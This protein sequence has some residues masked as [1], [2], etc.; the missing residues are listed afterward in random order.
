MRFYDIRIAD[1]NGGLLRRYTSLLPDGTP[2]PNALMVEID[3]SATSYA[4]PAGGSFVRIWG[5][6]LQELGAANNLTG[7]NIAVYGGMSKGLPLANP[8]QQGLLVQGMV[9]QAFGNW[10]GLDMTL[11]LIITAGQPLQNKNTDQVKNLTF[12]WTKGTPLSDII[13]SVL[14]QNYPGTTA[15]INISNK[16]V[17]NYDSPGYYGSLIEF[18]QFLKRISVSVIGTA[19]YQGVDV[20][21]KGN[22][23]AVFDGTTAKTPINISFIDLIG[24]PTW[25]ENQRILVTTVMR[26]DISVGDYIKLPNTQL[27][28]TAGSLSQYRQAPIFQGVYQVGGEYGI[29][30]IG[31]SRQPDGRSWIS[32]FDCY[33]PLPAA[34]GATTASP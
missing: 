15:D 28:T 12:T 18:A 16:L 7:K 1:A 14:G 23:F 21:L 31:S 5:I 2:D 20:V 29:H 22:T 11:D 4:T 10:I 9:Q 19:T 3:V 6:S 32:T 13:K 27:T 26:G 24:Q 33:P 34:A 30:H 8:Q 17:L 25:I